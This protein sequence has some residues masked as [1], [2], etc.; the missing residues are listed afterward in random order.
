MRHFSKLFRLVSTAF[1]F[2][3]VLYRKNRWSVETEFISKSGMVW[4]DRAEVIVKNTTA[5]ILKPGRFAGT[6]IDQEI[7]HYLEL[8]R[9]FFLLQMRDCDGWLLL[10][11]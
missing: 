4:G 10:V 7:T 9:S 11:L 5:G 2:D 6:D 8:T 1:N 3:I